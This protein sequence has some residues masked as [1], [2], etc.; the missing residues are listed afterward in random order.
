MEYYVYDHNTELIGPMQFRTMVVIVDFLSTLGLGYNVFDYKPSTNGNP[1]RW[2]ATDWILS[3][4]G[5]GC[6]LIDHG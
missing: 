3:N 5:S 4:V 2:T 6:E 1:V